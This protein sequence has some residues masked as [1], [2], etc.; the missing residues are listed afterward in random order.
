MGGELPTP[1]PCVGVPDLRGVF[2]SWLGKGH[3]HLPSNSCCVQLGRD[4]NAVATTE[5]VTMQPGVLGQRTSG[6][7][8]D[9]LV[10]QGAAGGWQ[11]HSWAPWLPT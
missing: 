1:A 10:V 9:T 7:L 5:L 4:T 3:G 8:A 2:L 11:R 6:G